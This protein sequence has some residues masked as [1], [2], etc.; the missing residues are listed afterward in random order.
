MRTASS[1]DQP[2]GSDQPSW[3]DEE[4]G[5]L[6]RL[7]AL[8]RGRT[9]PDAREA[10]DLIALITAD[11]PYGGPGSPYG[12]EP[13]L[14]PEHR[15][16]LDQ[17]REQPASVAEVAAHSDLP[18]GVVRVLLGDLLDAG[19]IRVSR[20]VPPAQLPDERLLREVINGLRAL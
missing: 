11:S 2:N 12:S 19:L 20:P 3:Y 6:V 1:D 5:P 17:C 14:S 7:F 8:T 16:I 4:A 9:R 10:F 15:T 18:V 13:G